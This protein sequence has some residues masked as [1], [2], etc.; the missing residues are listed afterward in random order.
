MNRLSSLACVSVLALVAACGSG[1]AEAPPPAPPP[2]AAQPAATA[3]AGASDTADDADIAAYGKKYVDLVVE[4]WPEAATSLGLHARDAELNDRSREGIDRAVAKQ[5]AMLDELMQRFSSKPHASR[6]AFTDLVILEHALTVD[7]KRT[8]ALR[9]HETRPDF[10]TEPLNA[11]FYVMARD[12]APGPE[13]AR[14]A[15]E[16]IEKLPQQV[17]SAKANLKNPSRIATQIGIESAEGA[18]TFL[19]EQAALILKEL[20]GEKARINTAVR[21]AKD[22]YAGYVTWLKK[23]L[24]PRSNGQFASGKAL[25]EFLT[26]EDYFLN[27]NSDEIHAMGKRLFDETQQKLTETA[28]RI[29]PQ[30]KKWSDVVARVKGHHPTMADLLPSYRREVA[31]AR[32]FL[33]DKDVVPFP[34]GDELEVVETPTFK[35]NT[36]QAA[37][38]IPPPFDPP[39]AKGFFYVTPAEAS[40]PK[41]RQEEWLREN[42]HGDQ[43]DTAVHEAYPGHH[44]QLSFARLHPSIIRKVT[45]PSIFS[46]GWGLYSEELMAELGYYTDEERLMQLVWTLVRAARVIIDVGLHTRGMTYEEAVKILTDEVHLE[47]PLAQNEVKRYTESPTQPL[48]YLIGRERIFAMRERMRARDGARFSLKAFHSEVLTR[49]TVAPGLLEREIFGD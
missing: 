1:S 22:A 14:S 44:L 4:L 48:S 9:P 19:D 27:E 17:Q 34:A 16:R 23:D 37:Y 18:K 2:V 26:H 28:R 35:R 13:R 36:T 10:Y 41:K 38:D 43:V 3:D 39:G 25:F 12:F 46:E 24:L 29:D 40:W 32:K 20:P 42:D 7:I 31:R 30:A 5:R 8:E 15:L 45:G 6:S 33:V 11:I 21:A 47:R 49:G